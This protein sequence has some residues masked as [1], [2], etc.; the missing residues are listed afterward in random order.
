MAALIKPFIEE[1]HCEEV[2]EGLMS[3]ALLGLAVDP[4]R[5]NL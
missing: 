3:I 5:M 1:I 2:I 4:M